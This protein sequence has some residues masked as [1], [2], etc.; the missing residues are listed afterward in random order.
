MFDG[1]DRPS[2]ES[3]HR[4][5]QRTF[6]QSWV[7]IF[8]LLGFCFFLF[9]LGI[10]RWDLWNPDE[11]RYAQVAKEMVSGGDWI[12]MHV[13]GQIYEDKPPLFFWLIAISSFLW[14]GFT[15]FSVRFP[16]AVLGTLT[17]ILTFFLGKRLFT[18][19]T[20]FL[21][22]LI[23]ATSFEFA[24]LSTRA[25]IDA[26]LTFFTTASLFCFHQWCQYHK[27][28]GGVKKHTRSLTLYG[29][30]V[31]MALATLAK[32]PV[33]FILPLLVSLVYL[34]VQK[35]WK[36]IKE[37]KLVSGML[38]FT[39]IVLSW[40]LPAIMKGG[41]TYLNETLFHQVIDRF[42]KGT[43]HIRP[44]YY[45]FVN[46]PADFLPWFLFLPGALV[47]VLSKKD[48]KFKKKEF[49]FPLVWFLTIFLFFS[50]SKGKRAIYLLP[51]YPAASLLVG[52]FW[53]AYR[54]G[55]DRYP[56]EERW[57][58]LPVYAFAIFLFLG[59][60]VL[61]LIPVVGHSSAGP[62]TS[63]VI[64]LILKGAAIGTEYL[65]YLPRQ[66]IVLIIFFLLVLGILLPLAQGL[67]YRSAVFVIIVVTTGM[68]FFYGTRFIFPL[69]NPYKSARF[70][71]QDIRQ[72]M[73]P[74]ERLAL[75]GDFGSGGT[76]PYNFYTGIVPILE[77]ESEKELID[78]VRM[79]ERVFCILKYQDYEKLSSEY[80]GVP[81][82]LITQRGVGHRDM[83][84]VSNRPSG[85]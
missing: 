69:V 29:F 36:S 12:L 41:Q 6:R 57:F 3:E 37:M 63:K 67:K 18:S 47:Y 78:F 22:G 4:S 27:G 61:Y 71:S 17:V 76:A 55:S 13:N 24:Y 72:T 25:D 53:D 79:N 32:G 58:S 82:H 68:G 80:P 5:S 42:S 14:R 10:G 64:T 8:I 59:G 73:K 83:A 60:I 39:A 20:G 2:D 84:L 28:E 44:F 38:L 56:V 31:S 54:S 70:I 85:G 62:S 33:G 11:P 9:I 66:T 34:S 21:S 15:S 74:G 26:T 48:K 43:S 46:F 45:Y 81:L 40:Y 52:R 49:L 16:G 35:K 50:I 77:I 65:S 23:L 51:L 1:G 75:Y 30:Y 19:R 7:P